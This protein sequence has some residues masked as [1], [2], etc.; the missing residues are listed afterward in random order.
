LTRCGAPITLSAQAF[1]DSPLARELTPTMATATLPLKDLA[2]RIAAQE[3]QLQA[4]RREYEA[5]QAQLNSLT[6]QKDELQAQLQHAE[7]EINAVVQGQV[8]ATP[9]GAAKPA[10]PAAAKGNAA[11]RQ[12]AKPEPQ[13]AQPQSLARLIVTIVGQASRPM[14]V[15]QITDE[16]RR[17]GFRSASRDLRRVVERR[18]SEQV[19]KGALR[20]ATGQPGV[21]AD[22]GANGPRQA[23][24]PSAAQ[25]RARVDRQSAQPARRPAPAKAAKPAP[26]EPRKDR[27]A[28]KPAGAPKPAPPREQ[29]SLREVLTSLLQKSRRPLSGSELA[30]QAQATGYRSTSKNF[31]QIVWDALGKMPSV[32]HVA[33]QGYQVKK[34]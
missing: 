11:A 13:P 30:R 21:I 28:A 1:P 15:P 5:R 29:P 20:R 25:Q 14:T 27:P 4:L 19:K 12:Q 24:T 2:R 16:V 33:G 6:R 17:R 8:R 23:A 10:P 7:A 26:P 32:E 34:R 22:R 3:S 9:P 31:T 18:V